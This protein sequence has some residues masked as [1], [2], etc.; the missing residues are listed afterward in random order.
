MNDT[1]TRLRDYLNAKA[2]TVPE[3]AH[4]PGLAEPTRSRHLPVLLSAAAV[5]LVV[6]LAATL[7]NHVGSGGAEPAGKPP[8]NPYGPPGALTSDLPRVPYKVINKNS[9]TLLDGAQAVRLP[10][11]VDTVFSR[12]VEGGWL[13]DQSDEPGDYK[14]GV[15]LANGTFRQVGPELT[16]MPVLSPD[17]TQVAMARYVKGANQGQIL[18]VDLATGREIAHTPLGSAPLVRGWNKDGV[19]F[20]SGEHDSPPT[21]GSIHVWQPGDGKPKTVDVP[22]YSGT[23]DVPTEPG[24]VVITTGTMGHECMLAGSLDD[25]KFVQQR[26]FCS[27]SKGA[28]YPVLAP[29]GKTMLDTAANQAVNVSTG[30]TVQ[31]QLPDPIQTWPEPVFED[32]ANVLV[33]TERQPKNNRGNGI[34]Q[35]FRCDVTSGACKLVMKEASNVRLSMP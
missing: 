19:W 12:R 5:V 25:G 21:V 10:A 1:E 4:G 33:K 24:N 30:K 31:F 26:K 8:V 9:S 23:L 3:S 22:G 27:T 18:V 7:L 14:S 20:T 15:L 32:S 17:R 29:D 6:G 11:G 28:V 2:G 13:A 35:L 16:D 34:E